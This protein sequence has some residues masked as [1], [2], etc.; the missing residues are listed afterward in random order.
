MPRDNPVEA[1]SFAFAVRSVRCYQHLMHKTDTAPIAKQFVR[2]ATSIGANVAEAQEAQS[3][4][5]FCAK[6]TIALKE[7]H[8]TDYWLRLMAATGILTPAE[9]DSL[10]TDCGELLALLTSILKTARRRQR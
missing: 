8:E 7:A 1:K 3:H 2:S 6:L 10:R 9:S 5:D 4:A